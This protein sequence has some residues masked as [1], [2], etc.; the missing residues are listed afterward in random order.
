MDT[1]EKKPK[2]KKQAPK[3]PKEDKKKEKIKHFCEIKYYLDYPEDI[4]N[5]MFTVT[6]D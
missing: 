5:R 2:S 1:H 6:F 3:N 4:R